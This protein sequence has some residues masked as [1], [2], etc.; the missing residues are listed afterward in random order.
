MVT[1]SGEGMLNLLSKLFS[2]NIIMVSSCILVLVNQG[3]ADEIYTSGIYEEPSTGDQ[4]IVSGAASHNGRTVWTI[5]STRNNGQWL[6]GVWETGTA[7]GNSL[8]AG[9]SNIVS[10][11]N[12]YGPGRS[13][14]II[15]RNNTPYWYEGSFLAAS[16]NGATITITGINYNG[17]TRNQFSVNLIEEG[18]TN[19]T[20]FDQFSS[21][22]YRDLNGF[23]YLVS[24]SPSSDER[25]L[26]SVVSLPGTSYYFQGI[27][28][29]GN[30]TG[31]MLL[32]G[33]SDIV[34]YPYGHGSGRSYGVTGEN[35]F[36]SWYEGYKLSAVQTGNIIYLSELNNQGATSNQFAIVKAADIDGA[37][38]PGSETFIG[39]SYH[40]HTGK[41]YLVSGSNRINGEETWTITS[42]NMPNIFNA[43]WETGAA[44]SNSL[45]AGDSSVWNYPEGYAAGRSYGLT[46]ENNYSGWYESYKMSAVQTGDVIY[47]S[48]LHAQGT[49]SQQFALIRESGGSSAIGSGTENFIGGSYEDAYGNGFSITQ[50]GDFWSIT[51][52]D[53]VSFNAQWRTGSADTNP[54][55]G[56]SNCITN[57]PYGYLPGRS[58]GSVGTNNFSGWYE[59]SFLSAIQAGNTISL[60]EISC[61]GNGG[62]QL[63]LNR[64]GTGGTGGSG[65]AT[66][67]SNINFVN[68]FDGTAYVAVHRVDGGSGIVSVTYSTNEGSAF[69]YADYI[70]VNGGIL[71][72]A[73]G[74]TTP[75]Y[76]EIEIPDSASAGRS[77]SISLSSPVGGIVIGDQHSATIEIFDDISQISDP[78]FIEI[79]EPLP[80]TIFLPFLSILLME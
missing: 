37:D 36:P 35:N 13:Y 25:T 29:T 27:W 18:A 11:P 56:D 58:Y 48:E 66:L 39:G 79:E 60:I 40:S 71:S 67:A 4:Y 23:E 20:P 42:V 59:G 31:N 44:T 49:T 53:G 16:G 15:G 10:Y 28:E 78:L 38:G 70:P 65:E 9:T 2:K 73:D 26:W 62:D 69:A 51:G 24:S 76:I 8:L 61:Y 47:F 77:F 55:L 19:L 50:A 12:G 32:A 7:I 22:I 33:S 64:G 63:I 1:I 34:N 45:I 52:L 74:D 41:H 72:W 3:H 5:V 6:E 54:L 14:G 21:G 17:T 46:G 30:A 43:T 80:S 57:Y 75:K 68:R